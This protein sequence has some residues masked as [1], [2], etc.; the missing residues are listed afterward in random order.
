M[1]T[2]F[3]VSIAAR[4]AIR[5]IANRVLSANLRRFEHFAN[6]RRLDMRKP[7][8]WIDDRKIRIIVAET[9]P[10][11]EVHDGT[12]CEG[13]RATG[14]GQVFCLFHLLPLLASA[15]GPENL[16]LV[17]AARSSKISRDEYLKTRTQ[18]RLVILGGPIHNNWAR[19]LHEFELPQ[20]NFGATEINAH[21]ETDP[22]FLHDR[23][24]PGVAFKPDTEA[25]YALVVQLPSV[26]KKGFDVL[27]LSGSTTKGTAAAAKAV[28][29][30]AT[31]KEI[32]SK[33]E[34][35][36]S[37]EHRLTGGCFKLR[38]WG[39]SADDQELDMGSFKYGQLKVA[40]DAQPGV[41]GDAPEAA[42]P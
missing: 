36:A 3:G 22:H 12:K 19:A 5:F 35:D 15:Y 1:N 2:L 26:N 39:A 18:R 20:L 9:Y 27:Y 7:F 40:P 37:G 24:E 28:A 10:K 21:G 13:I 31:L 8:P 4:L 34:H 23:N 17:F 16:E 41:P 11:S 25:D 6:F 33:I 29:T 32:V 38:T 42:R 14:E 30:P